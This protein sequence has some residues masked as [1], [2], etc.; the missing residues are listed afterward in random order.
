MLWRK[1]AKS[2]NLFVPW[3]EWLARDALDAV[4][5]SDSQS[6]SQEDAEWEIVSWGFVKGHI[7]LCTPSTVFVPTNFAF[8]DAAETQSSR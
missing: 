2:S 8:L 1:I 5:K 4:T 6:G 7:A 3:K